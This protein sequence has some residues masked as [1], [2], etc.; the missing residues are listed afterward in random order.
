MRTFYID[1]TSLLKESVDN[2]RKCINISY[3]R[4]TTI[5][6]S[7][8]IL[9]DSVESKIQNVSRHNSDFDSL[10]KESGLTINNKG[11]HRGGISL[12][13]SKVSRSNSDFDS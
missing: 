13:K 12:R 10:V 2:E 4:K 3:V 1:L 11:F 7:G 5:L 9:S 8:L 6:G